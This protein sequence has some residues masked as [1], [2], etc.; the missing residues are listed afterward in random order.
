MQIRVE[1]LTLC[2]NSAATLSRQ[3]FHLETK[4]Y[5]TGRGHLRHGRFTSHILD[6]FLGID[7]S[8]IVLKENVLH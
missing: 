1:L 6:C 4:N 3:S 8:P 2:R 5:L 7:R